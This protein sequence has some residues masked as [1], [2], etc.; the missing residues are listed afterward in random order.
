MTPYSYIRSQDTGIVIS[1]RAVEAPHLDSR[2]GINV[3]KNTALAARL[4]RAI[5]S[6][7]AITG[8]RVATDVYGDEYLDCVSVKVMGRYLSRDL[9]RMGF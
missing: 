3:G 6:G 8:L 5:D 7:K 2:F 4:M 1:F 9:Q